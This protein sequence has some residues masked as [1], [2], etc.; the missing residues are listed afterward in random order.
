[1]RRTDLVVE[2]YSPS[3]A[4]MPVAPLR[5]IPVSPS[6]ILESR[7]F[8]FTMPVSPVVVVGTRIR[9][10]PRSYRIAGSSDCGGRWDRGF[11]TRYDLESSYS[12]FGS[13]SDYG[14]S[15]YYGYDDGGDCR[16]AQATIYAST[17]VRPR[18]VHLRSGTPCVQGGT[19]YRPVRWGSR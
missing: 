6:C 17:P 13:S 15:S 7:D 18:V 9:S 3:P 1:M 11:D 4:I 8:A 14:S 16:V 2:R 12:Y 19:Y 5:V 10:Y